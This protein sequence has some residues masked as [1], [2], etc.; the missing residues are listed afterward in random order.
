MSIRQFLGLN[1]F[2]SMVIKVFEVFGQDSH[3][4]EYCYYYY[5]IIVFCVIE[6]A[7]FVAHH[8]LDLFQKH[9]HTHCYYQRDL[10]ASFSFRRRGD[11]L[12]LMEFQLMILHQ[13]HRNTRNEYHMVQQS[14]FLHPQKHFYDA[15]YFIFR[16][17]FRLF[18]IVQHFS[19]SASC[20]IE[21]NFSIVRS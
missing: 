13:V 18:A 16:F 21:T 4:R 10:V 5:L 9:R 15:S 2:A 7:E 12:L 19:S 20:L 6:M 14:C 3:G 17:F 1:L 8:L 11:V